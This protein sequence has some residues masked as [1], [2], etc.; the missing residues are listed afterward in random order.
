[1]IWEK[2]NKRPPPPPPSPRIYKHPPFS[3]KCEISAPGATSGIY[4]IILNTLVR[5]GGG[6]GGKKT[7]KK[8]KKKFFKLS[9]EY[10]VSK[11]IPPPPPPPPPQPLHPP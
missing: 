8:G 6:G 2:W 9:L 4:D 11:N 3:P 7:E 10:P 5:G 1:M